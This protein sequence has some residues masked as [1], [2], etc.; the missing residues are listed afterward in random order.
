MISLRLLAALGM[1]WAL[2]EEVA[3]DQ[4]GGLDELSSEEE[5]EFAGK[6]KG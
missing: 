6:L 1:S 5:E 3:Y 2:L 4:F